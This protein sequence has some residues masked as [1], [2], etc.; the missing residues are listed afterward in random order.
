MVLHKI[1][2]RILFFDTGPNAVKEGSDIIEDIIGVNNF[3][4]IFLVVFG[5]NI[6]GLISGLN[7]S[8]QESLQYACYNKLVFC[9]I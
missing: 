4:K 9:M 1:R 5:G 3:Y 8:R 2:I 7:I 6:S